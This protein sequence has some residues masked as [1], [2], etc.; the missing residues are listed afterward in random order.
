MFPTSDDEF[1][2]SPEKSAS[3]FKKHGVSFEEA[4]TVFQDPHARLLADETHS[5]DESRQI[6]IGYSNRRRLL[7]V[8]FLWRLVNMIRIISARKAD[9]GERKNYEEREID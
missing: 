5:A 6:L 1:E 4:K 3:N 7:L 8:A 2:W 9:R